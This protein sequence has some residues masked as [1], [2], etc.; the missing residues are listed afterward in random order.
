MVDYND[1][2]WWG[3]NGGECPES[4]H[5]SSWVQVVEQHGADETVA[6]NI[7]WRGLFGAFRVTK[8]HR[9]PR[10]FWI[11]TAGGQARIYSAEPDRPHGYT[12]VREVLE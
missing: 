9:E 12:H 10:E 4:V 1:G 8:V 7:G 11:N 2:N 6:K 5:P 3:W